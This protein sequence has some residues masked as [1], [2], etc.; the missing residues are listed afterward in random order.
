MLDINATCVGF[1]YVLNI[2]N[3]FIIFVQNKK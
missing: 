3:G 1:T 2:A